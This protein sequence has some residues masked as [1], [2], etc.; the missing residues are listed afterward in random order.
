[1][2]RFLPERSL[3]L[4]LAGPAP[5]DLFLDVLGYIHTPHGLV[6]LL[7][8]SRQHKRQQFQ[9]AAKLFVPLAIMIFEVLMDEGVCPGIDV[10]GLELAA[11]GRKVGIN[12]QDRFER[13]P[14]YGSPLAAVYEHIGAGI[15]E[16][17]R[18]RR[19]LRVNQH[20][21]ELT[22]YSRSELLGRSIF[23]VTV[24]EYADVDE[25]QFSRQV[26][27]EI[28][29]YTVAK[30]ITKKGGDHFWAEVTSSSVHGAAGEF[31]YAVRVQHDITARK[32]AEHEL[33][34]RTEEQAAL[35]Q[36]SDRLQR[37][38]SV[39]EIY[40]MALDA[41]MRAFDCKRTSILLLDRAAVMSFVAWRGLSDGYR[42]A[43]EGH[44]PWTPGEGEPQPILVNDISASDLPA[45]LKDTILREGIGAVAFI[46]ILRDGPLMGK[47]MAYYDQPSRLNR[48]QIEIGLTIARQLSF[49]L[50]RV[51]AV[52]LCCGAQLCLSGCNDGS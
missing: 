34:R 32:Q 23:Q 20:L 15:V 50:A 39:E 40:E 12:V 13:D 25:V 6:V 31:L 37:V 45:A 10:C 33:A 46:P 2:M 22:G 30:R 21:C 47:F 41:I 51:K 36:L 14:A 19:I 44:S 38:D 24:A 4:K 29:R 52:V 27:G 3:L 5:L 18:D 48:P 1:M 35:F 26:A 49:G 17:D 42:E 7:T 43:V 28:G 11:A 8:P 9:V 16:V